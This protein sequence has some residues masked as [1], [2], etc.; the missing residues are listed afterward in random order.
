MENLLRVDDKD[1]EII[2]NCS[3]STDSFYQQQ[4]Y[5][6]TVLLMAA[7]SRAYG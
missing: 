5:Q 1:D 3:V 6:Q 2:V 7:V 4:Q